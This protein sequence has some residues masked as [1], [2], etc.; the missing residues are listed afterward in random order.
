MKVAFFIEVEEKNVFV[1]DKNALLPSYF[2][3]LLAHYM[4]NIL[5]IN[6]GKW[7]SHQAFFTVC[8]C[9]LSFQFIAISKVENR[10]G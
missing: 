7:Y 8:A 5:K 9:M 6:W 2:L 3:Y 10:T 1:A 4:L